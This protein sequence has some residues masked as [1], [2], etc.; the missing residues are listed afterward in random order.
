MKTVYAISRG[1]YSD[2]QVDLVFE[3]KEDAEAYCKLR[4]T[5]IGRECYVEPFDYYPSGERPILTLTYRATATARE[6]IV[7]LRE[8]W[9]E[10]DVPE[11]H[12][13]TIPPTLNQPEWW[14]IEAHGTNKERVL[15]AAHD[16]AAEAKAQAEGIA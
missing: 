8:E 10:G 3:A 12:G 14:F 5:E 9:R 6:P 15:K 2:Y 16:R 1:S 7:V 13:H 11:I 4:N